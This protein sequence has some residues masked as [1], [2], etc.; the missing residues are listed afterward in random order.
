MWWK[1]RRTTGIMQVA[2][3]Q[4]L[5]DRDSVD[6]GTDILLASWTTHALNAANNLDRVQSTIADYNRDEDYISRV[7]EV[8][9]IL[10]ERTAP[11]FKPAYDSIWQ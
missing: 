1:K 3:P 6:K 7:F 5:S 2:S 11:R 8:M 9:N 10:A 4:P